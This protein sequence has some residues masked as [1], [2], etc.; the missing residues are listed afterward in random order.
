MSE[1]ITC[2]KNEHKREKRG[3]TT[4]DQF[5]L[6]TGGLLLLEP[7]AA[8]VLWL[9]IGCIG[10]HV[11]VACVLVERHSVRCSVASTVT[12]VWRLADEGIGGVRVVNAR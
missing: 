4:Y 8:I 3:E 7:L 10:L 11:G 12:R 2:A 1:P 9:A 6:A 5:R